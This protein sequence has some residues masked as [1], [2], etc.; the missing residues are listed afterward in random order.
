MAYKGSRLISVMPDENRLRVS[1]EAVELADPQGFEVIIEVKAAPI[2]PS[3]IY[4]MFYSADIKQAVQ[5][6]TPTGPALEAPVRSHVTQELKNRI[7]TPITVGNEGAGVVV[8]AGDE[9]VAQ[10]LLGKTVAIAGGAMY[11]QYCTADARQ[12]LVHGEETTPVQAASSYVN[13]MTVLT[14]LETMR[15]D[16]HKALVQSVAASSLGQMLNRLCLEDGIEIINIVRRDDQLQL[17][18]AQGATHVINSSEQKFHQNLIDAIAETRATILFDA[19]FGG[20]MVSDVMTCME[21]AFQIGQEGYIDYTGSGVFKQAYVYGGLDVDAM[22]LEPSVGFNWSVSS[23][24]LPIFAARLDQNTLASFRKKIADEINTTFKT[25]YGEQIS[26]QDAISPDI[27][28]SY[29]E[30]RTGRKYLVLP[31]GE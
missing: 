21:Q 6:D 27:A 2:N 14:M 30:K 7:N 17:L 15:R 10:A 9:S 1:L 19:T 24:V 25:E 29:N 26:L 5:V 20:H 3:D 18:K 23:F 16:G 11:S 4:R 8:A 28:R 31:N 12:C 22:K 13:P